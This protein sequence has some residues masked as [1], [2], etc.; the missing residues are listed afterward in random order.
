M[1]ITISV[2]A[3]TW[4]SGP[5]LANILIADADSALY[6]AKNTGRNRVCVAGEVAAAP[7]K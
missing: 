7:G 4:S 2:G 3:A 5:F 1:P 6:R